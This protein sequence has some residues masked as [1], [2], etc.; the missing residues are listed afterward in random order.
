MD[1]LPLFREALAVNVVSETLDIEVLD[2][3]VGS[4]ISLANDS[5]LLLTEAET[6]IADCLEV[7]AGN[8][9]RCGAVTDGSPA[10]R[11]G[12]R[13]AMGRTVGEKVDVAV[14]EGGGQELDELGIL[15]LF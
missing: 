1:I 4:D 3:P 12:E 8:V 14:D 2:S 5:T 7:V 10:L 15:V 6:T 11:G 13:G 9:S